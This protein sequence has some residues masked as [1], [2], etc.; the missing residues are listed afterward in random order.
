MS[1]KERDLGRRG[2]VAQRASQT[3]TE[4]MKVRIK[5][6]VKRPHVLLLFFKNKEHQKSIFKKSFLNLF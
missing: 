5:I 6:N 2:A 3:W 4:K 1:R